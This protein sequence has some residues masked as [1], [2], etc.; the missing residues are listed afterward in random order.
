MDLY[1]IAFPI[2]LIK[3]DEILVDKGIKK[4]IK[5]EKKVIGY[6]ILKNKKKQKYLE[7]LVEK[8]KINSRKSN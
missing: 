5:N 1:D 6:K 3:F 2:V 7:N 8:A 4:I